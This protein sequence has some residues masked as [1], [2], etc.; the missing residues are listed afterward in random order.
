MESIRQK[1]VG[2]LIQKE[3]GEWFREKNS[4]DF[5]GS[6]ISVT[7]VR[8]SAD[9]SIAKVYVSIYPGQI[10]KETFKKITDQAW[11]IRKELGYRIRKNLRIVPDLHFYLDDSLDYAMRIE[12]LLKK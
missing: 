2:K 1:K 3:L 8:I 4:I 12:E 10:A 11:A 7:V 9:L 6:M 5:P